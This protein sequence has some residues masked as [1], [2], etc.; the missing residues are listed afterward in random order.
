MLNAFWNL[1]PPCHEEEKVYEFSAPFYPKPKKEIRGFYFSGCQV[2]VWGRG[3]AKSV[4]GKGWCQVCV[5]GE[6]GGAKSVCGGKGVVPRLCGGEAGGAVCALGKGGGAKS[7]CGGKAMVPSLCVWGRGGAKFV[8]GNGWCQ[9]CVCMCVRGGGVERCC[10]CQQGNLTEGISTV[11]GCDRELK[12]GS[13][14]PIL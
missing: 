11:S 3:G 13:S 4:G 5:C 8:E 6:G 14:K 12:P 9:V 7:V 10:Q 2:C 1:I